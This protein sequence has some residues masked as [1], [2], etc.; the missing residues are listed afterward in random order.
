MLC[1]ILRTEFV[2]PTLIQAKQYFE[3]YVPIVHV[4]DVTLLCIIAMSLSMATGNAG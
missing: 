4:H 2:S 1:F 3:I